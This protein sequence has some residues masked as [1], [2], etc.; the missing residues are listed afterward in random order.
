ME[1]VDERDATIAALQLQVNDC[2]SSIRKYQ[3]MPQ[4]P[5]GI[6]DD[7]A[8]LREATI[9]ISSRYQPGEIHYYTDVIVQAAESLLASLEK[10]KT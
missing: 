5:H 9:A 3:T 1:Q 8:F 10:P 4:L 7:R 6:L 2:K